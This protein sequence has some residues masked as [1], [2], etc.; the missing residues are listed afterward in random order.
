MLKNTYRYVRY[1]AYHVDEYQCLECYNFLYH[2]ANYCQFC[3][4]KLLHKLECRDKYTTRYEYDHPDISFEREYL[5]PE[6]FI[7]HDYLHCNDAKQAL[8]IAKSISIRECKPV[9]VYYGRLKPPYYKKTN[10]C[11]TEPIHTIY[12][13]EHTKEMEKLKLKLKEKGY[14]LILGGN[15][16]YYNKELNKKEFII[17]W[18]DYYDIFPDELA[19][20]V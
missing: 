14:I 10:K 3:S 8:R 2:L 6:G 9:K 13:D 15:F 17:N 20:N 11:W 19:K 4:T 7:V 1:N 18:D 5:N 12:I 16:Y